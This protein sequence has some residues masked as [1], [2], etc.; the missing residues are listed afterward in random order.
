MELSRPLLYI[1]R[2]TKRQKENLKTRG[3][4][5]TQY[6]KIYKDGKQLVM[7]F[8]RLPPREVMEDYI[9]A[10]YTRDAQLMENVLDR[11]I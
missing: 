7:N 3:F 6:G 10:L 1:M 11:I 8:T 9:H 4:V 2:F 5:N